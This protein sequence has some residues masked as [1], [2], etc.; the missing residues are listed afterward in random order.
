MSVGK[1]WA[2]PPLAD[3]FFE[4]GGPAQNELAGWKF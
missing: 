4:L 2:G 1:G 3:Q